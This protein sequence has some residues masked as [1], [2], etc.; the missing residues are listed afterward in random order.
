MKKFLSVGLSVLMLALCTLPAFA[1]SMQITTRTEPAYQLSYPADMEIPWESP[2]TA[3]GAVTAEK[4]LI[5]PEK[6][7]EVTVASVNDYHLVNT[8]D[9]EK[10]I[11]YTL[12]GAEAMVFG[13]GEVGK[14]FSL[15]VLVA[16]DAWSK[17]AAGEHKDILTFTAE[18]RNL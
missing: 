15:N 14:S 3:I 4:L 6:V 10:S 18:Y 9:T 1:D 5:E 2:E 11:V 17:A 16:S 13:P 7:V 8:T 12:S